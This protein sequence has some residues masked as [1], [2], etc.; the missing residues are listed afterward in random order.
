MQV[1]TMHHIFN[2]SLEDF[3][4]L[5]K[6]KKQIILEYKIIAKEVCMEGQ[7]PDVVLRCLLQVS[8]VDWDGR[9]SANNG[10]IGGCR[11]KS[12]RSG[13]RGQKITISFADPWPVTVCFQ[14]DQ[15]RGV[16][17]MHNKTLDISYEEHEGFWMRV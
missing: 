2:L 14:Y 8:Q 17:R 1:P 12:F 11:W 13:R 5:Y 15:E 3:F 4:I 7:I 6:L 10:V 16:Y 9:W